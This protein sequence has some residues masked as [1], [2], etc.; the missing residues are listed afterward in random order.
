VEQ[1]QV[2]RAARVFTPVRELV[3]GWVS[4]QG[5][6][7]LALGQ[8]S[9]PAGSVVTAE[10][11]DVLVPGFVDIHN[12]GGGGASFADG[13]AAARAARTA[14][15]QQGTTTVVASLVSDTVDRLRE[16][17]RSLVPLCA[18]DELAGIHLE[19]PWLSPQWCGAHSRELL[20]PPGEADVRALLAAAG[21][22]LVMVTL[23]PELPGA[24]AATRLLHAHGVR[25]AVGHTDASYD[26]T[27]AAVGA[28]ATVATHL[29]NAVRPLH[30]REPGPVLALL[31][32]SRVFVESIVDGV[33]LHPAVVRSAAAA[34]GS[35]WVLV[36]DAMAG[37]ADGDGAYRLGRL[38]VEVVDGV[39]RVSLDGSLAGSTLSLARAV[40]TAVDIGV[41]VQDAVRAATL[42]PA[43]ALGRDDIG[44]L[45]PGCRADL[46]VLT[47]D[48]QVNAVMRAGR[49]VDR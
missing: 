42:A 28:G 39:A 8:G 13:P 25:V 6:R 15:L 37:A 45:E 10:R 9:P 48:L 23:A 29:Y 30:P 33:H 20:S 26:Q 43:S 7:V 17:I 21:G 11:Y 24:V 35:R 32:D 1:V 38:D 44:R 16:Q 22:A 18:S 27:R 4:V 5:D 49:W 2:V 36:T 47:A 34:A 19:G 14:H 46:V 3:E 41:P 40:R 31:E 12:H